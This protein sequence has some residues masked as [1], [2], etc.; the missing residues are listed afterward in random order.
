MITAALVAYTAVTLPG[1]DLRV[2]FLNVGEGDA[3]LIQQGSRQVLIDGGPSPQAISLALSEQMPFWDR[4]IDLVVLTH[5]HQDHLAGLVEVMRRYRVEQVLYPE[6]DYTS[7][8]YEEWARLIGEKVIKSTAARAGEQIELGNG[9]VIEVL[10]PQPELITGSESDID[11]N[12]V[13]LVLK[14]GKISFLLTADIMGETEQ[15]LLRE[16]ADLS[17]TVLKVAHHGSD[18]ST[19]L[20]FLA[21]V[22]PQVAIISCGA[23]N[24]FGHPSESVVARL[25]EK[26]GQGNVYRTDIDGTIS[27]TTDGERLWVQAEK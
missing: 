7:P 9:V 8:S 16:R 5:P 25:G 3:I 26:V 24:K 22:K 11:N 18:T 2:S 17:G 6:L 13:T 10:N 12:S 14:D 21:V 27:F 23:G 15:E 19:T 20:A 4:T 1:G